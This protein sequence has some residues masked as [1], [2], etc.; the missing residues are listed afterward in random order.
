MR[1]NSIFNRFFRAQARFFYF[2]PFP[3]F[4]KCQLLFFGGYSSDRYA[5]SA[6]FHLGLFL[7]FMT[8]ALNELVK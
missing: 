6:H 7:P 4:N 2:P 3:K 5:F 1:L 8:L